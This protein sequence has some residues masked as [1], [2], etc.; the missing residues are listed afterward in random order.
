MDADDPSLTEMLNRFSEGERNFA[1]AILREILPKLREIAARELNRKGYMEPLWPTE[2]VNEVWIRNLRNGGWSIVDR[3][4]FY[5]IAGK[6]MRRVLMDF[7]RMRQTHS[8]GDGVVPLPLDHI[9]ANA[10]PGVAS[11]EQVI[12]I[13]M[14]IEQME[15][16][17]PEA[18][19]V[20]DLHY[21]V[22]YTLQEI[23]QNTGVKYREV[24]RLWERARDWIKD[25][26]QG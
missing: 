23:A 11:P 3:N 8:R 4:H 12:E 24:R 19:R 20:F 6:A 13:G 10:Q 15:K 26:Y 22:G 5:F 21:F 7:A 25:R 16:N 18:A 9:P 14:L 1:E 17:D 2:L